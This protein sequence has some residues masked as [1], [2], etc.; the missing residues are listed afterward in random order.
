MAPQLAGAR[1]V[2][3]YGCVLGPLTIGGVLVG[4]LRLDVHGFDLV[5]MGQ[6]IWYVTVGALLW[7]QASKNV[8]GVVRSHIMSIDNTAET[9]REDD[10]NR[11]IAH[12]LHTILI[13]AALG[14]WAYV[15]KVRAEHLREAA[16]V[17]RVFLYART[18]MFEWAMLGFAL[19]GVRLNG[20]PLGSVL[21]ERWRSVREVARDLGIG[22]VFLVVPVAIGGIFNAIW[23]GD[24]S[25]RAVQ[26]FLPGSGAE[27]LLWLALSVTAGICEEAVYRGYFQRQ[28][29]ALANSVAAGIV[30]QAVLFGASHW[31]QGVRRTIP[32]AALGAA[33]GLLAH[34]RK[35][36]RPG[37][38]AHGLQ[39]A[40]AVFARR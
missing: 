7:R 17:N 36:L 5:V 28:F 38:V 13:L 31:Y 6:A 10:C 14:V 39:D 19:L 26:Y 12:P 22:V 27:K 3:V 11:R 15:S 35:S 33:L 8:P 37:M 34:W 1:G 4:H 25:N 23:P 30:M 21:G 32:I 40:M 2:G 29:A 18:M 20:S 24:S 9:P 16:E